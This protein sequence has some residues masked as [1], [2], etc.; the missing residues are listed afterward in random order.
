MQHSVSSQGYNLDH[1]IQ[2]LNA[3]N[4]WQQFLSKG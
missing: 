1:S 4:I 3:L 2:V